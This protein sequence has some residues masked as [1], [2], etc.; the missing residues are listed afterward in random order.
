M[1]IS[2]NFYNFFHIS[3]AILFATT[4]FLDQKSVM[5]DN[6]SRIAIAILLF[7]DERER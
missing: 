3:K 4:T 6:K 7:Q 5:Q 1:Q 2:I